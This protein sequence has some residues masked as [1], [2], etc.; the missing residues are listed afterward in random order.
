MPTIP[1][2]DMTS[3]TAA[4]QIDGASQLAKWNLSKL[5]A[6]ADSIVAEFADPLD[7]IQ[8]KSAKFGASFAPDKLS[9]GHNICFTAKASE[10]ASLAILRCDDKFLL[11]HDDFTPDIPIEPG[12]FWAKFELD[13][14]LDAALNQSISVGGISGFGVGLSASS[15]LNFSSY[16]LFDKSDA[17][18]PTLNVAAGRALSN[19]IPVNSASDVRA[20]KPGTVNVA[21]VSGTVKMTGSYSFPFAINSLC[22]ASK[23]LLFNYTLKVQ[24]EAKLKVSGEIGVT[25][26]YIIRSYRKSETA[27]QFGMFKKRGSEFSAGFTAITG[28]ESTVGGQ[29]VVSGIL[30]AITGVDAK[31]AGLSDEQAGDISKVL[32]ESIDRSLS[33]SLNLACSAAFTHESAVIYEITLNENQTDTDAALNAAFDGD[34]TKLTKL[35]NAKPLRNVVCNCE[36]TKHSF[37]MNLLGVY[38]YESSADFLKN[39]T[40]LHNPE[41]HSVTITDKETANSVSVASTPL[42]A[43]ANRLRSALSEA[44]LATIAY[45]ALKSTG[46]LGATL[47]CSENLL[48]YKNALDRKDL[49]HALLAG[50]ALGLISQQQSQ[51]PSMANPKASHVRIAAEARFGGDSAL[52]LFF[53]DLPSRTPRE[54]AELEALGR[55][56]MASLID[57]TDDIGRKRWHYLSDDDAWEQMGKQQFPADSSGSYTDW[58]AVTFWANAVS[59]VGPVLK[60]AL[61]A[62][63]AITA[64][65]PS[66]DQRFMKQRKALADS[67][68]SA[69][70]ETNLG[71]EP[72]WPIAITSNL[73]G[74]TGT[75]TFQA[76]WDGKTQFDESTPKVAVAQP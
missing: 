14:A 54:Y 28:L 19:F 58:C 49:Q 25:G 46:K 55:G 66:Q 26:D 45:A 9:L 65:D 56:V 30:S 40:I 32:K 75:A 36:E 10:N 72:A 17:A 44:S 21:E 70:H 38:N 7:K 76:A 42:T 8:F 29:D 52:R 39:C 3:A 48:I 11:G 57:R 27:L 34:W 47:E 2:T 69:T 68:A 33:M 15:A 74:H 61:E 22:L 67:L 62:V 1:I 50:V 37:I 23:D 43:D 64:P 18:L 12:Q 24:P 16:T 4:V 20:Q 31:K 13:T 60:Q 73:S 6:A 5:H 59:K 53:A 35:S 71:F 51:N 41:D 63:D